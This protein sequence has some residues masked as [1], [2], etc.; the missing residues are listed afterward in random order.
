MHVSETLGF[1]A[2]FYRRCEEK[3]WAA[4]AEPDTWQAF[5]T[6]ICAAQ[7]GGQDASALIPSCLSQPLTYESF[8]QFADSH[9]IGGLPTSILAVESLYRTWTALPEAQVA[10]SQEK[11]LYDSDSAAHMRYLYRN[12]GIEL[13]SDNTLP[14]DH[15]SLLLE[16]LG[17]LGEY[18]PAVDSCV[19]IDEHLSWL[20]DLQKSIQKCA[21]EAEWLLAITELL[22]GYLDQM[23]AELGGE[24]AAQGTEAAPE[25]A[26]V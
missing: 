18:A 14:P 8:R 6:H 25:E 26:L 23:R 10:F 3:D 7:D 24:T 4:L 13:A 2:L 17:L 9:F 11:G 12:L 16:F 5:M 21:P 19:F 20:P 1:L 22:M 15:L